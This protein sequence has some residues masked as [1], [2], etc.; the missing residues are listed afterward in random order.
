[1][2]SIATPAP[3]SR[4]EQREHRRVQVAKLY[5]D[6]ER[7]QSEI[8]EEVGLTRWQVSRLLRDARETGIVRI[9]IVPRAQRLPALESRMQKAFGLREAIIV[10]SMGDGDVA[11]DAVAQAA[12][13]Y[14]AS[15]SPRP[16]LV[17]VSWGRT[18]A[19][20]AHWL[21]PGWNDG[22]RVV[23]MNGATNLKSATLKTNTVG[24]F[25]L[26]SDDRSLKLHD[27]RSTSEHVQ[28]ER[29]KAGEGIFGAL[30]KRGVPVRMNSATGL[31]GVT[32]YEPGG[33]DIGAILGVPIIEGGGLVRGVLV[34]DRLE[35][36]PFS[37]DDERLLTVI[38]GE[39]LRAIEVE[40]VMSY[41]RQSRDEKDRFFRAI[42]EL[43]RAG[44]P[45]QVFLAVLEACRQVAQPEFCAV[46][47]VSEQGGQRVHRIVR[48]SGVT[49][50][51]RALENATFPDNNGLVANVVR[52]GAPEKAE[53]RDRRTWARDLQQRIESLRRNQEAPHTPQPQTAP[54]PP[55]VADLAQ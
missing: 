29:F 15:L 35:N 3:P 32:H 30:L 27:C 46:T 44:S 36:K 21:A 37:E 47:L 5:Y 45:E 10:P 55:V 23:L 28:R 7:T 14:L 39:V 2:P 42:E 19:S 17:G 51:G 11:Q 4:D 41:I 52:Y 8:A 50:A 24:V 25:M 33:P 22:V 43:N 38:A 53:G 26:A 48:M 13:Q 40:R 1:M 34:A 49:S 20:V 6:L 54:V 18:M 16:G 9:A 31:K 12:G